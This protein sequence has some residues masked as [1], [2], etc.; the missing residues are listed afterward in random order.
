MKKIGR[1]IV[2]LIL[3][4][5]LTNGLGYY[6]L[7]TKLSKRLLKGRIESTSCQLNRSDVQANGEKS[8]YSQPCNSMY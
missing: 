5:S 3:V 2:D 7:L 1:Y 6:A 4:N 8:P